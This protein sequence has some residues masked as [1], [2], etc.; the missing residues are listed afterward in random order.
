[1]KK[2]EI[3]GL[4]R[5]GI[6][7]ILDRSSILRLIVRI[8]NFFRW[9]YGLLFILAGLL[10]IWDEGLEAA[11]FAIFGLSLLPPLYRKIKP[12]DKLWIKILVPFVVFIML[13]AFLSAADPDIPIDDN[14]PGTGI[15]ITVPVDGGLDGG[16]DGGTD[17]GSG[18]DTGK[19]KA[20]PDM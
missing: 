6:E 17:A 4:Y 16:S 18:I 19:G 20:D 10:F 7:G 1:M 13:G 5:E 15:E 2:E 8:I 11:F 14:D 3:K 12:L 9:T